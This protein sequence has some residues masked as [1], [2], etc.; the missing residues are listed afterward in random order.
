MFDVFNLVTSEVSNIQVN[1]DISAINL[2]KWTRHN[3]IYDN[4]SKYSPNTPDVKYYTI[5]CKICNIFRIFI[6]FSKKYK[7]LLLY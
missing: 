1:I 4:F 2:S 3:V 7:F 5:V 6:K